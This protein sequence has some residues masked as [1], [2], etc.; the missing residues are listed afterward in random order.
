MKI[1]VGLTGASGSILFKR[2][3]EILS[4]LNHM[5]LVIATDHGKQVFEYELDEQFEKFMAN[6]PQI[7]VENIDDMF[8][9]VASG[10][11]DYD[12]MIIVPCSMGTVGNIANGTSNNLLIRAADVCLKEKRKLVLGLR[13]SPLSNIHLKNLETLNN[14]GAYLVFQVPSFYNKR[15]TIEQLVDD[16]VLRNIKYLGIELPCEIQWKSELL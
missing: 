5:L 12:Q 10:S 2:T 15:N 16:I 9:P 14:S 1:I 11:C 8:S 4:S 7:K 6:Y 3:I 13:E